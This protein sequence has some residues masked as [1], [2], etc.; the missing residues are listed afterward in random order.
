MKSHED[1]RYSE[2]E[3]ALI[4]RRAADLAVSMD[5]AQAHPEGFSLEEMKAIAME[6]GIDPLLIERIARTTPVISGGSRLS[7][8]LGGPLKPQLHAVIDSTMTEQKAE[9]TLRTLQA[10]AGQRGQGDANSSG[11]TWNSLELFVS[12]RSAGNETHVLVTIDRRFES[13][14]K[15]A[16]G[17]SGAL[18]G[19]I[20]IENSMP[21]GGG[22]AYTIFVSSLAGTLT[23][24]RYMWAVK[25][26]KLRAKAAALMN[27]VDRA[28]AESGSEP[29]LSAADERTKRP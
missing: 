20:I 9:S 16:L 17:L 11:V 10:T 29:G 21:I 23:M 22:A 15:S 25:G 5:G 19:V 14:V 2:Q 12:A 8:I 7:R 24:A 26:R 6:A 4:L 18:V 3:F 13:V 28:L 1:R 27:A